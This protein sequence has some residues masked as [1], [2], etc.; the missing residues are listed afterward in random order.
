MGSVHAHSVCF[1][2]NEDGQLIA[3]FAQFGDD[4]ETSPGFLDSLEPLAVWT[5]G[6]GEEPELL[7]TEKKSDRFDLN[8]SAA[9]DAAL[10]TGFPITTRGGGPVRKPYFYAR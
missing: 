4:P 10:Q 6:D 7:T 5:L 9:Q 1:E 3:R 8:G 2:P